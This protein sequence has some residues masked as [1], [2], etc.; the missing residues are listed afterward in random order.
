MPAC[1]IYAPGP[2]KILLLVLLSAS[3][4]MVHLLTSNSDRTKHAKHWKGR[5]VLELGSGLGH[6]AWGL[7]KL[8]AH[9]TCTDTPLGDLASLNKRIDGWLAEEVSESHA[10]V[11]SLSPAAGKVYCC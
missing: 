9:V 10:I 4:H 11:P 1:V 6:M 2:V 3:F 5:K 7:Y 8:G